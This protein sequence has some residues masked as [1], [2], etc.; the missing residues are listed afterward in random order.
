M[1]LILE[2]IKN[3][4][5]MYKEIDLIKLN[6]I[7]INKTIYIIHYPKREEIKYSAEKIKNIRNRIIE[8]CCSTD[9]GSS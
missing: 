7:H 3:R 9:N 6:K 5:L 2:I 1:N 4:Y 8:T